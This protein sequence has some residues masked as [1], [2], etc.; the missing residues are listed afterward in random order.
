MA[1]PPT[2]PPRRLPQGVNDHICQKFQVGR[3]PVQN[4][5]K[6]SIMNA[7][8]GILKGGIDRKER[9]VEGLPP[10]PPRGPDP[11]DGIQEIAIYGSL[12]GP[13]SGL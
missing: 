4:C 8:D 13:A 9:Q 3:L 12:E 2:Q 11:V 6:P 10:R 5:R 7:L 1:F